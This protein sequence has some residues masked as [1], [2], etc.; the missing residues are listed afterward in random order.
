MIEKHTKAEFWKCALQVNPSSYIAYRGTNHDMTE[1]QYNQELLRIA[2]DNGI[3]VIGL[4]D[5]GNVEIVGEQSLGLEP[6]RY[7]FPRECR[8]HC[9]PGL[10]ELHRLN[11]AVQGTHFL[12]FAQSPFGSPEC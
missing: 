2:K 8:S 4:A 10:P 6:W 3:K 12:G 7:L 9:H 5:H 11:R 1:A